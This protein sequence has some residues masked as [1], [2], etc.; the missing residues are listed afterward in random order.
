MN[1]SAT[2]QNLEE[3]VQRLITN[4]QDALAQIEELRAA[5][6]HQRDELIRTHAQ[7]VQLQ[8]DYKNLH[9]AHALLTDSPARSSARKQISAIITKVDKTLELLKE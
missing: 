6:E 8:N 9:T 2:I 3:S 1:A 7:L 4:Y 5:N